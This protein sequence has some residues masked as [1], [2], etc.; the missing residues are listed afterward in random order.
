MNSNNLDTSSEIEDQML[1]RYLLGELSAEEQDRL[2]EQLFAGERYEELLAAEEDLIE[3]SARGK[4]SMRERERFEKHFLASPERRARVEFDQLLLKSLDEEPLANPSPLQAAPTPLWRWL[5][6]A[7][8]LPPPVAKVSLAAAGLIASIGL[9]WLVFETLQLRPRLEQSQAER[10]RVERENQEQQRQLADERARN[11]RLTAELERARDQI[12]RLES[13]PPQSPSPLSTL[14]FALT[15]YVSKSAGG[16]NRLVI[17]PGVRRL[18][19]QLNFEIT[20][21]YRS[22]RA[23]LQTV[24]GRQ[25][26]LWRAKSVGSGRAIVILPTRLFSTG[27]YILTL[28]GVA[29]AKTVEDLADYQFTVVKK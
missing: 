6:S 11:Q 16:R 2:E 20:D 25:I 18:R 15:P 13:A 12:A 1:T 4:L 14:T 29:S 7:I 21:S 9:S 24:E 10:A 28:E 5:L 23:K 19:L 22:L 26:A 27:D 8:H 17:T 3:A